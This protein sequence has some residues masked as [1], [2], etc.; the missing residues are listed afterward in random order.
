MKLALPL[1]LLAGPAWGDCG[2]YEQTF[3][4]CRITNSPNTLSVCFDD[5]VI[6]YRFGPEQG[7]PELELNEQ[8]AAINY[9]PW[10]G[11]GSSIWEEVAFR[12]FDHSYTVYVGVERTAAEDV[13]DPVIV[14]FTF[15]GVTVWRNDEEIVTFACDRQTNDYRGDGRLAQAKNQLGYVWDRAANEWVALPD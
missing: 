6:S 8:I 14:P 1:I 13:A 5:T 10:P 3:L 7:E 15:G 9:T 4:H 2:G 12:N 11:V